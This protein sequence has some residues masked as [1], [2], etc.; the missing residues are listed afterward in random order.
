[1]VHPTP[2][3]V[4]LTTTLRPLVAQLS[5]SLA[6]GVRLLAQFLHN[7]PTPQKM[8]D[9]ERELRTLLREVGRRIL[10]WILNRLEPE[11]AAE[12]PSRVR[13]EGR[14]YRRR[15][16]QRNAW[17][18]LFGP[19][20][21]WRR[22]YEPLEQGVRSLHPLELQL[23]VEAG[24]ATPA[25]AE[26]V[27]QWAA[28]HTQ[29]AVLAMLEGDHNVHWSSTSLRKVLTSLSAGMAKH[30]HVAQVAQVVHGLDQ[31]RMSSYL[32]VFRDQKVSFCT[33][34]AS[35]R[36]TFCA[37]LLVPHESALCTIGCEY[38]SLGSF[39]RH[40][41]CEGSSAKVTL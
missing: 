30:R 12:A 27:G 13:F 37:K 11:D 36:N 32:T 5:S 16:K 23:G 14:L 34:K 10:A 38:I 19:V 17:V 25:F 41:H 24:L 15:G 28:N 31:A 20:D 18:T 22:L 29:R 35:S 4:L 1:M 26:R 8:A 6:H 40:D 21:V 3:K 2:T 33:Q 39:V 9:F 7:E